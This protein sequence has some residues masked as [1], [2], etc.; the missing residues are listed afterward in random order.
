MRWNVE[1]ADP[2]TGVD[3]V[4]QIEARSA[5]HAESVA[6]RRGLLVSAVYPSTVQTDA[7]KLD[8][9]VLAEVTHSADESPVPSL[10]LRHPMPHAAP[11][12]RDIVTGAT[13][14]NLCGSAATILGAIAI[15]IGAVSL[16]AGIIM[17]YGRGSRGDV[18]IA[19]VGG[20]IVALSWGLVALVVGVLLKMLAALSVAVRDIA[21]NSFR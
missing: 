11:E 19:L 10:S 2:G 17:V 3:R 5:D 8:A 15:I 13:W 16:F 18:G 12:Y 7:E 20:G 9:A 1:A 14:L 6:R 21:R 4:I